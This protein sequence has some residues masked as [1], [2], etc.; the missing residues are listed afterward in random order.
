M[1]ASFTKVYR[2]T[3]LREQI[4]RILVVDRWSSTREPDMKGTRTRR[5]I[6]RDSGLAQR[7]AKGLKDAL[8]QADTTDFKNLDG[9]ILEGVSS[10]ELKPLPREYLHRLLV[11]ALS[12]S[13]LEDPARASRDW[14]LDAV[15]LFLSRATAAA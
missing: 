15:R 9:I 8:S 14:I 7:L 1:E 11:F 12:E 5:K 10:G 6:D 3:R 2:P 4:A 13:V